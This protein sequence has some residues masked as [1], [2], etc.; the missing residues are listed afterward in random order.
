MLIIKDYISIK[1]ILFQ[2]FAKVCTICNSTTSVDDELKD[3][4]VLLA[5]CLKGVECDESKTCSKAQILCLGEL[6]YNNYNHEQ[7]KSLSECYVDHYICTLNST[8]N[9]EPQLENCLE[10]KAEEFTKNSITIE[11][12]ISQVA[13]DISEIVTD[14][15][16]VDG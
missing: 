8:R 15:N 1:F 16:D 5:I 12:I 11:D 13:D 4:K 9:C 3:P 6:Q 10:T 14:E 2:D 7:R